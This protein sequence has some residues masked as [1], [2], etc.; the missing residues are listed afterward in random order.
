MGDTRRGKAHRK[1]KVKK[2]MERT[3]EILTNEG[4]KF[5]GET[6]YF[7]NEPAFRKYTVLDIKVRVTHY[8][9]N[10]FSSSLEYILKID[11]IFYEF[12]ERE[13]KYNKTL[14]RTGGIV[15][16]RKVRVIGREKINDK[17]NCKIVLF[18]KIEIPT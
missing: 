12:M 8:G 14:Q 5:L 11:S 18:E 13:K 1:R 9:G 15:F 6:L 7:S 4:K 17:Q 16:S 10:H 3:K 2:N